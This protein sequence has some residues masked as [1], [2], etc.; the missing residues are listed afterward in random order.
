MNAEL[1]LERIKA[2][3]IAVAG[4]VL[5]LILGVVLYLRSGNLPEL[6]AQ[7]DTAEKQ[8]EAIKRNSINAVNLKADLE[9]LEV[10]TEEIESRL[11]RAGDKSENLQYFYELEESSEVSMQNPVLA[12]YQDVGKK[13]PLRTK[14]FAQLNYRLS[15]QGTF[16]AV[17]GFMYQMRTGKHFMVLDSVRISPV[18]SVSGEIVQADVS[19]GVL[20]ESTANSK[21]K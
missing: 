19:L 18:S 12:G 2:Y 9:E 7:Y 17:L 14:V 8:V 16:P 15:F 1:I 13:S 4:L 20:A 21:K 10:I 6:Q 11:M 3:P 5:T